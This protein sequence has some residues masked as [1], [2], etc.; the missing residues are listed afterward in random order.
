MGEEAAQTV[1]VQVLGAVRAVDAEGRLLDVPSASQ[2]RL[3]ALLAAH[4]P[5]S[6]RADLLCD[7]LGVSPGALRTTVSRLRRSLGDTSILASQSGY[8]LAVAVDARLFTTTLSEL[9][10]SGDRI[11][12]IER[13]LAMWEGPPLDEFRVR[14][15]GIA[16]RRTAD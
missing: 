11:G 12:T 14:C 6:L 10:S 1:L 15:L 9:A 4:A 2:R 16:R 5:R 3:L 13:A 7:A 8:R